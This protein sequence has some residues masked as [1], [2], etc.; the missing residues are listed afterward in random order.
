VEVQVAAGTLEL[1][2]P[3]PVDGPDSERVVAALYSF[4]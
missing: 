2:P 4:A 3:E 1:A